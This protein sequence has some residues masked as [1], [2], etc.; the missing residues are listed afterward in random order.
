MRWRRKNEWERFHQAFF[1]TM[2]RGIEKL[3]QSEREELRSA[4]SV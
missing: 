1:K 2:E 3:P 4:D